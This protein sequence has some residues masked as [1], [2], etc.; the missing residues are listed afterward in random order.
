MDEGDVLTTDTELKLAQRLDVRSRFDITDRPTEFNDAGIGGFFAAVRRAS[1][2]GF[3]PVLHG[4]G[5]VGNHLDRFP[6]VVAPAFGFDHLG[7]DF[8]RRQVVVL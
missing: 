1:G 3:D 4:V 6:E 5:D 2:H 8:A 7:V